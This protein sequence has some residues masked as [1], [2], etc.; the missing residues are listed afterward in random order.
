MHAA[1]RYWTTGRFIEGTDDAYVKADFS[2]IAP[3]VS[4]Y[5]ISVD[6]EDNQPVKAGQVL[7]RLDDHD[8]KTALAAASASHAAATAR[9]TTLDAKVLE[10][11]ARFDEA[12]AQ[13]A[14]MVAQLKIAS[15]NRNRSRTLNGIGYTSQQSSQEDEAKQQV[16]VA[17]LAQQQA[18]ARASQRRIDTLKADRTVAIARLQQTA[19]TL[20]QA[21]LNLTYS[22]VH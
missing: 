15:I 8:F 9:L 13:V 16:A 18:S 7:A 22:C 6:V 21:E 17:Q 14:A 3:R 1:V 11:S 10:Q 20:Q 2:V 12:N 4:G 5:V 19:A